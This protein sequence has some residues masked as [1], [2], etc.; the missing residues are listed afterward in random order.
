MHVR[1]AGDSARAL[2]A[3][4]VDYIGVWLLIPGHLELGIN[5]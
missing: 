4:W 5:R 1:V 3:S 2:H